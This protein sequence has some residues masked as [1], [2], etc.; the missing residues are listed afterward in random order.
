[1]GKV[2]IVVMALV[3]VAAYCV[4]QS[5]KHRPDRDV[6]RKFPVESCSDAQINSALLAE[7]TKVERL[8]VSYLVAERM[9]EESI[10]FAKR[11]AFWR[12]YPHVR[13]KPVIDLEQMAKKSNMDYA[14]M[15]T[16]LTHWLTSKGVIQHASVST[17]LETYMIDKAKADA[18]VVYAKYTTNA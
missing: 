4:V 1:M 12:D 17:M 3:A 7:L 13:S 5:R 8:F 11:D 10:P 16:Q 9:S 18:E 15:T 6:K 2:S 14:T